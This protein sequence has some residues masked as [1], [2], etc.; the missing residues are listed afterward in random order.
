[1]DLHSCGCRQ[2]IATRGIGLSG[3][4]QSIETLE[5]VKGSCSTPG[6]SFPELWEAEALGRG[7]GWRAVILMT[8]KLLAGTGR[9][10]D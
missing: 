2:H 3:K 4:D 1:M 6:S 10:D 7:C 8:F 9:S 5:G